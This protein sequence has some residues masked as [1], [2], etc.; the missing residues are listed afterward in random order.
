VKQGDKKKIIERLI[1]VPEK[2]KRPFWAREMT[3]LNRLL[4]RWPDLSFW[5]KVRFGDKYPSLAYLLT[6][7]GVSKVIRKY[8]E[9]TFDIP[10]FKTYNLGEKT[11]EDSKTNSK[12]KSLKN[13]L[14]NE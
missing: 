9:F 14:N 13:F 11:G 6:D 3:L 1:D 8:N 4:D 10:A 12:P 2:G 5:H 7:L